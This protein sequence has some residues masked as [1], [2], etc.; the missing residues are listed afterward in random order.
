M[1]DGFGR[2]RVWGGFIL[3]RVQRNVSA[4]NSWCRI[5]IRIKFSDLLSVNG[6]LPIQTAAM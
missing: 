1:G 4:I 2:G 6:T 5:P 3:G